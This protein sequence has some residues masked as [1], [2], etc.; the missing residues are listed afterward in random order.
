[1]S[2]EVSVFLWDYLRQSRRSGF[3][4]PLS[5]GMDSSSVALIVYNMCVL[6]YKEIVEKRNKVVQ[7]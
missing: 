1:V 2:Y 6:V 5:G 7:K 3:I 4:L